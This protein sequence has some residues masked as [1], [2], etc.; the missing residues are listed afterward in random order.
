MTVDSR[1]ANACLPVGVALV[2]TSALLDLEADLAE[3]ARR[4]DVHQ[5][6]ACLAHPAAPR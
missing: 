5:V 4:D 2:C 3:A 1:S 6:A